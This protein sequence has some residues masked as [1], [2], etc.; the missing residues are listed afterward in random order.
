[1]SLSLAAISRC[2]Q[3]EIPSILAT[4][5]ANGEPNVMHVSQVLVVD[6]HH[7]AT[8]NQFFSKT[9]ANLLENPVATLLCPDPDTGLSYKLLVQHARSESSG[10]FFEAVRTD[11]DAIATM[12]GMADVFALRAV[13]IFRVLDASEVPS[14][15]TVQRG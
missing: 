3:G 10:P 1:M 11:L 2:L 15:G 8:S 14:R 6:E 12:T 7:V 5:S 4:C 9:A 13:D